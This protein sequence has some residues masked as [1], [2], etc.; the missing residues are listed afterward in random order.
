MA[1]KKEKLTTDEVQYVAKLSRLIMTDDEAKE[2][3]RTLNDI[4]MYMDKLGELD[5]SGV[6]PMTHAI[7]NENVMRQDELKTFK[8]TKEILKNA[9]DSK[10]TFF[11]V[12]KVID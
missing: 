11:R 5:T 2:M 9:P 8:D 1:D 3:T 7:P 12:P 4:L 10:G 6:E